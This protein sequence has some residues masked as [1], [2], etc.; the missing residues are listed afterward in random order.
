MV[1]LSMG[2]IHFYISSASSHFYHCE[3]QPLIFMANGITFRAYRV[4][5][6]INP[7]Y[8]SNVFKGLSGYYL[9]HYI[10]CAHQILILFKYPIVHSIYSSNMK[11]EFHL[12]KNTVLE[13]AI[14]SNYRT[15][16]SHAKFVKR[17]FLHVQ[18]EKH[19]TYQLLVR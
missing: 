13:Y 16:N 10:H 4:Y 2:K 5:A 14:H 17:Q 12:L 3:T 7:C 18:M 6:L 11:F 9:V 8:V 15:S 19:G 1:Q